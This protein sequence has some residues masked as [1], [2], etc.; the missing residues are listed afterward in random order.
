MLAGEAAGIAGRVKEFPSAG[1]DETTHNDCGVHWW[2]N[3]A[4]SGPNVSIQISKSRATLM[5][6]SMGYAGIAVTDAYCGYDRFNMDGRHQ[7]CWSHDIRKARHL[8]ERHDPL[9]HDDTR[10]R[11]WLYLEDLRFAFCEGK[12]AAEI[13]AH[14]LRKRHVMGQVLKDVLDRYRDAGDAA[15]HKHV[16]MTERHLPHLFTF[17]EHAG[18]EPTNNMSGRALR[19]VAVSRKIT[20][21]TKGGVVAMKR[22]GDFISCVLTWQN[23]G[24]SVAHEV[25]RLI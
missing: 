8:A 4:Q 20:G 16:L 17:V 12:R 14:P 25:A 18:V 13:G 2:A 21:Q 24:K 3:V 7:L 22:L 10:K 19:H 5:L 23:H 11:R 15:L 6:D 9:L 1:F